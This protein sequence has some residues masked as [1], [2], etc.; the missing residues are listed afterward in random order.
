MAKKKKVREPKKK[1]YRFCCNCKTVTG[2][3]VRWP[4]HR[5]TVKAK[6]LMKIAVHYSADRKGW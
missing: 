1:L 5:I 6:L 2:I 4:S 3:Q